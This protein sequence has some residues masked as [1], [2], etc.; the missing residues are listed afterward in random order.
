MVIFFTIVFL[1]TAILLIF[2][3]LANNTREK[4]M[5][6]QVLVGLMLV[7][8]LSIIVYSV[9]LLGEGGGCE[10]NLKPQCLTD[11]C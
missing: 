3:S 9:C 8:L 2:L 7:S 1:I 10:I 5:L 4:H 6:L 11:D